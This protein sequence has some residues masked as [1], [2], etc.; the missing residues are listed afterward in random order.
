M[1]EAGSRTYK[2]RKRQKRE[3]QTPTPGLVAKGRIEELAQTQEATGG[4]QAASDQHLAT[5]VQG[6]LQFQR[7]S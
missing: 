3:I 1:A 5:N 4:S 7:S 6:K 2:S